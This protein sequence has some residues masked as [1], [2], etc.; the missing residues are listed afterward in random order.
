MRREITRRRTRVG[1]SGVHTSARKPAA[2]RRANSAA[3]ILS[4]LARRPVILL[5]DSGS[6]STTR[7]TCGSTIRAIAKAFAVASIATT[8]SRARL[9]A[10]TSSSHGALATC[11]AKR[12]LPSST[13]ATSQKSR[14]TSTPMNLTTTSSSSKKQGGDAAG[15]TTTTDPCS[16]HTRASRGGGQLQIAGSR[17]I[18]LTACPANVLPEPPPRNTANL[19]RAPD[20][21]G[22]R[23]QFHAPTTTPANTQ[24]S[25]TNHPSLA[26]TSGTNLDG[27]YT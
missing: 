12:N 25:A 13:T 19:R 14:W 21:T 24:P 7:A 15:K 1:S 18:E 9:H 17:P 8:S 2:S 10:N 26:S 3:S 23:T 6:A 22:S 27:T 16:K 11:P 20:T 5:T 4:V